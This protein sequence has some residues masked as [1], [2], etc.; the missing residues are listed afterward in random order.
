MAELPA[1]VAELRRAWLA[2]GETLASIGDRAGGLSPQQVSASLNATYDIRLSSLV[3]LAD[4]LGFDVT[5]TPK[6]G[7]DT[8][9]Q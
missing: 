9:A 4:V 3:R 6:K 5:L 2:S 7:D 8:T 1:V